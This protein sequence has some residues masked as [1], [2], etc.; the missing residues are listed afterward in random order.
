MNGWTIA[1]TSFLACGVEMVE[2]LTIV[3][4][5]GIAR[6]WHTAVT[7]AVWAIVILAA[8]VAV[9]RPVLLWLEPLAAFKIGVGIVAAYYG[10][11]W[12]RKAILRAAGRKALRDEGAIYAKQVAELE[13]ADNRAA[14]T[15]AFNGVFFE[16]VEAVVIVLALAAGNTAALPWA[17]GGALAALAIVVVTGIALHRPLERVPENALKFLVGTMLTTFGI[18]W[19]GEGAGLHWWRDDASIA[20]LAAV[21]FGASLLSV[22]VLRPARDS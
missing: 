13:R 4:A 6:G 1:G 14:F 15:T 20:L 22:R 7:A 17:A 8:I 3:L 2:A 9:A 10:L 5:A 16:G 12:L 21:I 11:G 18:F 19:I